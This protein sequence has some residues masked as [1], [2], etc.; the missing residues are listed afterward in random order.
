MFAYCIVN[1]I[2]IVSINSRFFNLLVDVYDKNLVN[3]YILHIKI[4]GSVHT[5]KG[6][7]FISFTFIYLI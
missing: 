6:A 7:C 3:V 1:I 4:C 5:N 2:I